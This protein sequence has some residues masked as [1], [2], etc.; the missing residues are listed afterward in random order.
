[1]LEGKR[2]LLEDKEYAYK[3][4]EIVSRLRKLELK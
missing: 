1:M 2:V 4:V 3:A